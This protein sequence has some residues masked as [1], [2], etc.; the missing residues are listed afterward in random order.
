MNHKCP[1]YTGNPESPSHTPHPWLALAWS[2]FQRQQ[3]T[4]KKLH[5]VKPCYPDGPTSPSGSNRQL[6]ADSSL[7]PCVGSVLAGNSACALSLGGHPEGEDPPFR[8]GL[9]PLQVL[10][11]GSSCG[12]RTEHSEPSQQWEID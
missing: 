2:C 10:P 12:K 7:S 6:H 5:G 8:G 1:V 9:P 4:N 11:E 3:E